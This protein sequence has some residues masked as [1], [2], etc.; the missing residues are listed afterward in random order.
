M[1]Q[2]HGGRLKA[3]GGRLKAK[4]FNFAKGQAMD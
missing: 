4:D 3:E 2:M 1:G